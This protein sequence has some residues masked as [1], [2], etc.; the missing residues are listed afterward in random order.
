MQIRLVWWSCCFCV[1][2]GQSCLSVLSHLVPVVRTLSRLAKL[3]LDLSAFYCFVVSHVVLVPVL[4]LHCLSLSCSEQQSA[5]LKGSA[6]VEISTTSEPREIPVWHCASTPPN[7]MPLVLL[8]PQ[9]FLFLWAKGERLYGTEKQI[10]QVYLICTDKYINFKS[11][12]VP[13]LLILP[14]MC[15]NPPI[16]MRSRNCSMEQMYMNCFPVYFSSSN[17]LFPFLPSSGSVGQT[18]CVLSSLFTLFSLFL[19]WHVV[20]SFLFSLCLATET[21]L[22]SH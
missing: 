19:C 21:V 22:C 20:F 8:S 14:G 17:Y 18:E 2:G 4:L 11:N 7:A 16:N 13:H 1:F 10:Q 5:Q 12:A 15:L 6:W 3:K 9:L